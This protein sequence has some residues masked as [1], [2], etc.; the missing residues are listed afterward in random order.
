MHKK[1][2]AIFLMFCLLAA[3]TACRDTNKDTSKASDPPTQSSPD[4][5]E[6][7]DESMEAADESIGA[8]DKSMG[9]TDESMGAADGQNPAPAG[10]LKHVC[11]QLARFGAQDGFYFF[12]SYH[13]ANQMEEGY[14]NLMYIDYATGKQVYLCNKSNCS[15]DD[16]GCT[17]YIPINGAQG[18]FTY[19][20][21]L[22]RLSG[23]G[24]SDGMSDVP[25]LFVSDL[26]GSNQKMLYQ[27]DSGMGWLRDFV[28]GDGVLYA[29]VM[30]MESN[31]SED[32]NGIGFITGDDGNSRLLSV[33]LNTGKAEIVYDLTDRKIVG[34]FDSYIV[35]SEPKNGEM[36]FSLFDTAP[37]TAAE[38]GK[39]MGTTVYAH[40]GGK[41]Y[42]V[43]SDTLHSLDLQSGGT[44]QIASGLPASPDWIE[45]YNG[46]AVCEQS[47]DSGTKAHFAVDL[48]NGTV[49][50]INL[51][52][53]G[54]D[55]KSP[56]EIEAEWG[57]YFLVCTG[58]KMD[59]EYVDWAGVWQEFIS[60]ELFAL[61]KKDD[62]FAGR[63]EYRTIQ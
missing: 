34:V 36:V 44:A 14:D 37:N 48:S 58:Y 35:I 52:K 63:A 22:Y 6:P 29:D 13:P 47:G 15:H 39:V 62:F 42:Y 51:S 7:I 54:L 49:S 28:I 53:S 55:F 27:L 57:E 1:I 45:T 18:L 21:K 20:D 19:K 23:A 32:E 25:G 46:F 30:V 31:N 59:T 43:L 8:T 16:A 40:S 11:E 24:S 56:I 61:I 33:N 38:A 9:A 17:S 10:E 50:Q 2:L 60:E 26:D 5:D 41:I 12:K 4:S 3:L